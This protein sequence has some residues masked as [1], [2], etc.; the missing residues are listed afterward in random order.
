MPLLDKF[1]PKY[2]NNIEFIT[3]QNEQCA[4]HAAQ[5]Y[6]KSSGK[7]G[8]IATTSGP[9]LTNLVTPIQDAYTDGD[10]LVVLSAQ[11]A[12]SAIGTGAFQEAPSV[13]I[14]KSICKWNYRI[15]K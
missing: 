8:V 5:G 13:D 12:T 4:G 2:K 11:V 10:P 14:T 1:H 6:A 15:K 3:H 7:T 9:G